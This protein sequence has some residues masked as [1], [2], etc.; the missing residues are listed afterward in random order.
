M[1][2]I[3]RK[4]GFKALKTFS[5]PAADYV[6]SVDVQYAKERYSATLL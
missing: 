4:I 6:V 2:Q 1:A 3:L 5:L